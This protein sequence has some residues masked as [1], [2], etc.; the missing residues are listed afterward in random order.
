M[1]IVLK[2]CWY[3]NLINVDQIELIYYL[4]SI[5]LF[6]GLFLKIKINLVL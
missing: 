6:F 4:L 3:N 2:A 1:D 5:F